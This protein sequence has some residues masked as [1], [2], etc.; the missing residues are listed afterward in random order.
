MRKQPI[1][2]TGQKF[3]RLT[4]VSFAERTDRG[5]QYKCKCECGN[6]TQACGYDLRRGRIKS[7][8]CIRITGNTNLR[9]AQAQIMKSAETLGRFTVEKMQKSTGLSNTIVRFAMATLHDEKQLY[10]C[11]YEGKS[12]T[13][14]GKE[15]YSVGALPDV[16][17]K[18]FLESQK[19]AK[20]LLA[21]DAFG[22]LKR[23][24]QH[25]KSEG[26]PHDPTILAL[27]GIKK[28]FEYSEMELEAA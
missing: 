16:T 7:C 19:V 17:W 26:I 4:V 15:V 10:I 14:K 28:Q 2:I 1:D 9:I 25:L 24:K 11:A 5:Y 3:G 13:R 27:L 22:A 8:G 12:Q 20:G 18:E 6:E 21:P 23:L